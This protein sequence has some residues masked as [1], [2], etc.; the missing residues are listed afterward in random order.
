[1][2]IGPTPPGTGV[3]KLHLGETSAK[4]TS[5]FKCK[6]AFF[7]SI[8]NPC[9][10]HINHNCAFFYHIGFYKFRFA[11]GRNDNIT[12]QTNFLEILVWE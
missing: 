5:P 9:D 11:E 6:T 12:A 10:A 7:R 8:R 3:I 1:M 2:V 4:A